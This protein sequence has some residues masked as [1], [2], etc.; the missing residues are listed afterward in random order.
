MPGMDLAGRE[1][2]EGGADMDAAQMAERLRRIKEEGIN[3]SSL[4]E[5]VLGRPALRAEAVERLAELLEGAAR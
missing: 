4:T 3:W 2:G 1:P 5:A